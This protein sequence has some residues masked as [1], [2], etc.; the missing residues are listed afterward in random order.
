H[1]NSSL[2]LEDGR[3]KDSQLKASSFSQNNKQQDMRAKYCRLNGH[4]A[5]CPDTF[6]S[7]LTVDLGRVAMVTGIATQGYEGLYNHYYVRSYKVEYS[8]DG[9][10]WKYITQNNSEKVFVGNNHNGVDII[11]NRFNAIQARYIKVIPVTYKY[12]VCLRMELYGCIK[13]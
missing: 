11:T 1:C 6:Q 13:G 3:I 12:K 4:L 7:W 9:S 5:W 2:G 10:N 8:H